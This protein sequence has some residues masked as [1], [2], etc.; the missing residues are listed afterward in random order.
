MWH[1]EKGCHHDEKSNRLEKVRG[2]TSSMARCWG[3]MRSASEG[4]TPKQAASKLSQCFTNP[5]NLQMHQSVAVSAHCTGLALALDLV[6]ADY[7]DFQSF[8]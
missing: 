1:R 6:S 8:E 4:L 7:K 2:C 3:S 5:P